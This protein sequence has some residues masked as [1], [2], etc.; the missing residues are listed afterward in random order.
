[1]EFQTRYRKELSLPAQKGVVEDLA[2][3]AHAQTITLLYGAS[4][5][6]HNQAVVLKDYIDYAKNRI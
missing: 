1:M 6:E 4:D 5:T 2:R 3:L